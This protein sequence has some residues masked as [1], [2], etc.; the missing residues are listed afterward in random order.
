MLA[1]AGALGLIPAAAR[2]QTMTIGARGTEAILAEMAPIGRFGFI[3]VDTKTGEVVEERNADALMIPASLSKI[4][5]SFVALDEH[6]AGGSF[7]T[8][9][10]AAGKVEGGILNG[11]LHLIG[12]GDPSLDTSHLIDMAAQLRTAG[13]LGVTGRF[14][15]HAAA[16]PEAAWLD[17]SQPW[18]APYN[19]SMGGLNLNY[20]RIRLSWER[21]GGLLRARVAAVSDG[22]VVRAPSVGIAVSQQGPDFSHRMGETDEVWTVRQNLLTNAGKRW[23]PVRLPGAFTAGVF[24]EVC[25]AT[26]ITLPLAEPATETAEGREVARHTS[27]QLQILLRG[28]MRFSNNLTAEALGASAGYA[29]GG[30]PRSIRAAAGLTAK[31][32]VSEVGGIGGGGWNG[33]SLEN[34]SGLSVRSRATPRQLAYMLR[35]G[36]NRWGDLYVSRF[37]DRTMDAEYMGLPLGLRPPK[38]KLYGKTGSMHFVHGLGG[39]ITVGGR[40]MTYAILANED[41]SRA[42]LN[43]QFEPYY[44]ANPRAARNWGRR[45]KAFVKALTKEWVLRHSA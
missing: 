35:E 8:R 14:I 5:A 33:F 36:Q 42:L 29:A 17:K 19:P 23:L 25:A 45:T 43:E 1:G 7:V 34:H 26:G 18:Q 20:N 21:T 16:L 13:I 31:R 38:H 37:N 41:E 12:G 22:H 9:I 11:D 44:D 6:G 39:F 10:K 32:I 27:D 40:Q 2:G 3:L 28:M 30:R 15:Y 24:R 4:P